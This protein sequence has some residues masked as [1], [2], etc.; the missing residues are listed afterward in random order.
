MPFFEEEDQHLTF[1]FSGILHFISNDTA[2]Q[3]V[4]ALNASV[5]K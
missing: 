1:C 2:W 5:R 3:I 4:P